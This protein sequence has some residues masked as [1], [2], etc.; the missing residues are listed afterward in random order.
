MYFG[1][2]LLHHAR[3][4]PSIDK[5]ANFWARSN[6]NFTIN[7]GKYNQWIVIWLHF[8]KYVMQS[9]RA[10]AYGICF[11]PGKHIIIKNKSSVWNVFDMYIDII[12]KSC[13]TAGLRN[14]LINHW[15]PDKMNWWFLLTSISIH[16][17]N[18]IR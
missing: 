18:I 17:F 6:S 11:E 10:L 9:I 15:I 2:R 16:S 13:L 12:C 1:L 3:R 4:L 14:Y 7:L 8:L 5:F